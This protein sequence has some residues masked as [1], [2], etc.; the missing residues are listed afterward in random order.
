MKD[1]YTISE[2]ARFFNISS[3]TLRYY[4]KIGLYKPAYVEKKTGYRYYTY[5]QFFTLSLIIQLKKLNFSLKDIQ[6]YSDVKNITYL[7]QILEDEQRIIE[8]QMEELKKQKENN[9]LML[10]KIRISK[11][12]KRN[13]MIEVR[14]EKERYE[15]QVSINFETKDLYQY[16]K[17]MYESYL[18]GLPSDV[19]I[20][21]H[22]IVMKI[23]QKNLE[24][25]KFKLYNSIG[26]FLDKESMKH[27][28]GCG[29][30]KAGIYV[31]AYHVGGYS[32]IHHTYNRL[33][34][35]IQENN[36]QIIGDSLEFAIVSISLTKNEKEFITEIQIPVR[37]KTL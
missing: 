3:Q 1:K 36:Y 33:Y 13:S 23:N 2:L 17:L 14:E 27:Q 32:T 37:A 20:Q 25:R 16:I 34:D 31:T 24:Q 30:I 22:E 18:K 35:Y 26:F 8:F 19:G 11:D 29:V 28:L 5:E 21:H 12:M 10:E 4:D 15:Y 9:E 6:R 7:E